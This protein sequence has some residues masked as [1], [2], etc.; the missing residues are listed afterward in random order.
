MSRQDEIRALLDTG[1]D[2]LWLRGDVA[3]LLRELEETQMEFSDSW[4]EADRLRERV[5]R[6]TDQARMAR[7]LQSVGYVT[8]VIGVDAVK[9]RYEEAAAIL[10]ALEAQDG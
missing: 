1:E 7:A 10:A 2:I 9:W 4:H 3:Y 8:D 6:F 5:A